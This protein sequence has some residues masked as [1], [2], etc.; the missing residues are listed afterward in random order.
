MNL[1]QELQK[2]FKGVLNIDVSK[3]NFEEDY[4]STYAIS[5]LDFISLIVEIES[6]FKIV[7]DDQFLNM[8]RVNTFSK[9][10]YI[11][12]GMQKNE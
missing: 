11:I 12:K 4:F 2:I 9:I 10:Y 3:E 8:E 1:Y 6:K 7:L 5:S